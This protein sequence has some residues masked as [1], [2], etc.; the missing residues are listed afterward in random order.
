MVRAQR[1]TVIQ[2]P[3]KHVFQFIAMDFFQNYPRWSPEVVELQATSTGPVRLGTTGRQ[4]R[5]DQGRRTE[6][7][8]RVCRF[9]PEC[10]IAFQG[11]PT[12]FHISYQL[13]PVGNNTRLT[14]T[15]ELSRLE[16]YM[17]PFEKLI[18]IAM[19]DGAEQVTR[20]LK[21]QIEAGSPATNS[22]T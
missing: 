22:H 18:R 10:H 7:T 8:F 19:Q 5:I 13:E 4:V 11:A 12:P 14:F 6:S 15:F 1:Q 3:A 2:R 21:S 17:R 16:F 9:E 20:N